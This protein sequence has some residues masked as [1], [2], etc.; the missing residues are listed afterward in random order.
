[1]V[2]HAI[3]RVEVVRHEDIMCLPM[4]LAPSCKTG[5]VVQTLAKMPCALPWICSLMTAS[6]LPRCLSISSRPWGRACHGRHAVGLV[7]GLAAC[8]LLPLPTE[9]GPRLEQAEG[10]QPH[11][12]LYQMQMTAIRSQ[13]DV[14]SVSGEMFFEWADAC[15]AWTTSQKF[16][17]DYSYPEGDTQHYVTDYTSWE[18]KDGGSF[19]FTSKNM[20]DGELVRV[21]RGS[22]ERRQD[23]AGE[24]DYSRPKTAS[25]PIPKGF[26]F[27][28]EHTFKLLAAARAGKKLFTAVMFDGSDDEGPVLVNAVI[29]KKIDAPSAKDQPNTLLRQSGWPVRMAFFNLD[30]DGSRADYEMSM[31][32]LDNGIVQSMEIDYDDFSLAGKLETLES[33]DP[34]QH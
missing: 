34:C 6:F 3:T 9:A 27:P 23:G 17:L 13:Q 21:Y 16:Q 5:Y 4:E 11:K 25:M 28:S 33:L 10:F 32:L 12:A 14:A 2:V 22:A 19:S 30:D 26:L 1:M 24:A 15:E 20:S 31:T 18:A 29:G 8:C 7:I